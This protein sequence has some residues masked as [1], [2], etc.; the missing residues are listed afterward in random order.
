MSQRWQVRLTEP[1]SSS[2]PDIDIQILADLDVAIML[3]WKEMSWRPLGEQTNFRV[4]E[5]FDAN[6]KD[7][8]VPERSS[9][10]ETNS[11]TR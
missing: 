6:N 11:I 9:R 1:Y 8:V 3:F 2:W 4:T 7:V 5:A 10:P